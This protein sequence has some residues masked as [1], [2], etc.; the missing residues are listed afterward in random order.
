LELYFLFKIFYGTS[1]HPLQINKRG[2]PKE[3]IH[4]PFEMGP[5]KD[6]VYDGETEKNSDNI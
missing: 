4:L 6:C 1:N 5:P 2:K 3:D